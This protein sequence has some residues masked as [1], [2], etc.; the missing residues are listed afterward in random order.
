MLE[1]EKTHRNIGVTMHESVSLFIKVFRVIVLS[2]DIDYRTLTAPVQKDTHVILIKLIQ[3]NNAYFAHLIIGIVSNVF[4]VKVNL[5]KT[6]LQNSL[7]HLRTEIVGKSLPYFILK[8]HC[9]PQ[10]KQWPP[11]NAEG[12]YHNKSK[13]KVKGVD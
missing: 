6:P 4:P 7:Q 13:G 11:T 1:R 5:N 3:L 8:K 2:Q 10:S 9:S 12:P